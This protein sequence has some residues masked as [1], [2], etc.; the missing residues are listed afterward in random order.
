MNP[1]H[2]ASLAAS[3]LVCASSAAVA[4]FHDQGFTR[5]P[6][7]KTDYV[8]S[9]RGTASQPLTL[10]TCL[11]P[12]ASWPACPSERL[13]FSQSNH[14]R[15]NWP[16]RWDTCDT[17]FFR[18][19]FW[20]LIVNNEPR[21]DPGNP[22]PPDQSLPR[23][24]PGDGLM[25]FSTLRGSDNFP[26]D[27]RWRAHLVMSMGFENPVYGGIPFLGFGE[28]SA[29]GNQNRPIA[30]LNPSDSHPSVL[31]FGSRLWGATL[32]DPIP[33]Q[34]TPVTQP[35]TLAFYLYVAANWGSYAK[36]IFITLYHDN[37]ENS[38]PPNP[39]ARNRW[40]W[41]LADSAF[42][43]GAEIVYIDAE[44]VNDY[45]GFAIPALAAGQD[46]DYRIDLT[47]LFRCASDRGLFSEALPATR[48]IPVTQVLWA[49]EGTGVNGGLW[50]DVH[51]MKTVAPHHAA[52]G[53]EPDAGGGTTSTAA[54]EYGAETRKIRD[55]TGFGCTTQADCRPRDSFDAPWI[56]PR[57]S[58]P[59][60]P[61]LGAL[62]EQMPRF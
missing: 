9:L 57:S 47:A 29:R 14:W 18:N 3:V 20:T 11:M 54:F 21:A 25:G 51:G 7:V 24:W 2:V 53:G 13:T 23:S 50:T 15:Q 61:E 8:S 62:T 32:P 48:N 34:G 42:Y 19:T 40:Q 31:Q 1:S 33:S 26:G 16:C 55:A 38:L 37:I 27:V 59:S 52:S 39:P 6:V 30:Y 45:C 22:G 28:F 44:D 58:R 36:A 4:Q 46:V 35:P 5:D 49:N 17:P 56:L 41:P 43:S 60:R 12:D 10:G